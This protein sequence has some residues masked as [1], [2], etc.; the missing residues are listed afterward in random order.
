[1]KKLAQF[2]Q[3]IGSYILFLG[4]IF[5]QLSFFK[6]RLTNILKQM[7]RVGFDS[8]LLIA[9]TSAFTGMVTSVQA[10][11]QTSGYIPKS[12]IGV[13]VAKSTMIE[14]APVLTGLVLAG[15]VGA[16]MAAEIGS[17][18]VTEQ[19]DA[20]QTMAIDPHNFI[21]LPRILAGLIMLPIITI[22]SNFVGIIS[23]FFLSVGKYNVNSY[24]FFNNMRVFFNPS[25]LWGG[26]VK[27]ALF[28]FIITTVACFCGNRASGGA[29]GVGKVA[30]V[31][32]VYS[33]ILILVMDFLVAAVLFGD[34]A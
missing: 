17:M 25:D 11:Y 23:A 15:K 24:S 32:V 10:S 7:K 20:L 2:F 34:A 28:G 6:K 29:E 9:I 5:L 21:Y 33:S 14:L 16:S 12:L 22:F 31:T 19:L 26:L 8:I 13:L 18:K 4:N 30:T 3:I 1:M 27:A